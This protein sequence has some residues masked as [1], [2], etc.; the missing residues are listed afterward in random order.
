MS[1]EKGAPKTTTERLVGAKAH[2]SKWSGIISASELIVSQ[3]R[4]GKSGNVQLCT[5][6]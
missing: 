4:K 2:E 6:H 1:I 5:N 3:N